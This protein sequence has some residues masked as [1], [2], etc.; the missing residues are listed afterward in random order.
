MKNIDRL[1]FPSL[2]KELLDYELPSYN[3]IR[4]IYDKCIRFN[5]HRWANEIYKKYPTAFYTQSDI[6][7]AFGYALSATKPA[8]P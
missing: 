3:R 2:L 1:P 5:H 6:V 4:R 7:T 8:N